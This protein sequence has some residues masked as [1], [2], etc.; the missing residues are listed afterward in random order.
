MVSAE[1]YQLKQNQ[2]KAFKRIEKVIYYSLKSQ[3]TN[4]QTHS[5]SEMEFL[6]LKYIFLRKLQLIRVIYIQ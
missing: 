4:F 5:R 3:I 1:L 2:D 6:M